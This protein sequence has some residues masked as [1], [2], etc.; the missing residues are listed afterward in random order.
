M[1]ELWRARAEARR[2]RAELA[3]SREQNIRLTS[4]LRSLLHARLTSADERDLSARRSRPD[5]CKELR[6]AH[7]MQALLRSTADASTTGGKGNSSAL[8]RYARPAS[9][10]RSKDDKTISAK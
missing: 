8:Q 7:S 6:R 3:P 4:E 9:A 1:G 5:S 10:R 2:A